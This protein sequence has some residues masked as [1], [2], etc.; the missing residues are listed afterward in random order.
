MPIRSLPI[1]NL[2]TVNFECV[3]PK[4]GGACCKE[5]RPTVEEN[6]VARIQK[7]LKKFLPL[8]RPRAE[9]LV[10]KNGFRTNRIKAGLPTVAIVDRYCVFYNEGCVLHK[11]G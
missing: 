8:M 6:E 2:Q 9:A 10:R 4:C 5:S 7:N 3:Y 11:V 1:I